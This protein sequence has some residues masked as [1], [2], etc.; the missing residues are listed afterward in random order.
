[1]SCAHGLFAAEDVFDTTEEVEEVSKERE[2]SNVEA[3][4]P[5]E[6]ATEPPPHAEP[7]PPS[8]GRSSSSSTGSQDTDRDHEQ[9]SQ[10]RDNRRLSS[11]TTRLIPLGLA[12]SKQASTKAPFADTQQQV[13]DRDGPDLDEK[14]KDSDGDGKELQ[15]NG[16]D[17]DGATPGPAAQEGRG[18]VN[19]R[20]GNAGA[21]SGISKTDQEGRDRSAPG[22]NKKDQEHQDE[23]QE[24]TPI[25]GLEEAE[26]VHAVAPEEPASNIESNAAEIKPE[27]GYRDRHGSSASSHHHR[28]HHPHHHHRKDHKDGKVN[29]MLQSVYSWFSMA[30]TI[31]DG[32]QMIRRQNC[33]AICHMAVGA[34]VLHSSS[35]SEVLRNVSLVFMMLVLPRVANT[36]N[37]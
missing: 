5:V 37:L 15:V 11:C 30:E 31:A 35:C 27:G 2:R 19:H 36:R 4:L 29:L 8:T 22:Q 13:S 24:G 1:M 21:A 12:F 23:T 33:T 17:S 26:T 16:Q 34:S 25:D 28:H 32:R 10:T 14:G 6:D 18:S 20:P 9:T 7:P 3:P